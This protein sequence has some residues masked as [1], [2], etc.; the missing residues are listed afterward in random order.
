MSVIR[1]NGSIGVR[2]YR[3]E[4]VAPFFDAAHESALDINPWMEWCHPDYSLDEAREWVLS[5]D[6]MWDSKVYSLIIEDLP[7]GT[8]L[9][10]VGINRL[11]PI[12]H[13]GNLGYWVRSSAT[14]RGIAARAAA[15]AA[16]FGFEELDLIRLD[17]LV[18]LENVAS[19]RVAEKIGASFEGVMRHGLYVHGTPMD[20][21]LYSLIR[22]D[23]DDVKAVASAQSLHHG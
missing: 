1:T 3:P 19:R 13:R 4:D 18:G 5:Q 11:D 9:G 14:R 22:E 15:L 6:A 8:I 17:V 20:A 2:R 10:S 21:A 12:H 7:S 23:L 16:I